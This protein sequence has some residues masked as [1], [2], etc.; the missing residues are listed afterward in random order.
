V[1][2]TICCKWFD[3]QGI[4]CSSCKSIEAAQPA[5]PTPPNEA[6]VFASKDLRC[7]AY[8][9]DSFIVQVLCVIPWGT[10]LLIV[11]YLT[12]SSEF[13]DFYLSDTP[14]TQAPPEPDSWSIAICI[15]VWIVVDAVWRGVFEGSSLGGTPGKRLLGLKVIGGSGKKLNYTD[16]VVRNLARSLPWAV[17]LLA[18][19]MDQLGVC[20]AL[21]VLV[22]LAFI[23]QGWLF[24]ACMR[25]NRNGWHDELVSAVVSQ[26]AV[27]EPWRKVMGYV[28]MIL[29]LTFTLSFL[30][31]G[32][33]NVE[34]E[35]DAYPVVLE[36]HEV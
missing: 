11:A 20:S 26:D 9:L 29:I 23:L 18:I 21:P 4:V 28:F 35:T 6:V 22:P 33:E 25:K 16:S 7:A 27:V 8:I 34:S 36:Q 19:A 17:L 13:L 14:V 1:I 3:G 31:S 10:G 12:G 30:L 32:D 2:C 5:P 24:F 15:A